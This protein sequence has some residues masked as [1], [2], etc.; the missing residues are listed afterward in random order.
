MC[1]VYFDV[2]TAKHCSRC[3]VTILSVVHMGHMCL[4]APGGVVS[5]YVHSKVMPMQ[6]QCSAWLIGTWLSL[7]VPV[8]LCAGGPRWG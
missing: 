4:Y 8:L 6:M 3:V 7:V 1:A 5:V 2:E